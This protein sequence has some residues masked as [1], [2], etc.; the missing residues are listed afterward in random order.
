MKQPS[1]TP[2]NDSNYLSQS[3]MSFPS[4]QNTEQS[5]INGERGGRRQAC[6][7]GGG[8]ERGGYGAGPGARE[9]QREEPSQ[10]CLGPGTSASVPVQGALTANSF[11]FKVARGRSHLKEL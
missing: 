8:T 10:S 3:D 7:T 4:G 1:F 11:P 5:A 6:G 9:R 2:K